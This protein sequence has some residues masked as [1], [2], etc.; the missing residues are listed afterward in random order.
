MGST[1]KEVANPSL[2]VREERF[3]FSMRTDLANPLVRMA[4]ENA[5]FPELVPNFVDEYADGVRPASHRRRV[6]RRVALVGVSGEFFCTARDSLEERARV[7]RL[8]SS[9]GIATATTSTSR[10]SKPRPR[11]ATARIT[12]SPPRRS[13]P[14]RQ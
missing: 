11:G 12:G 14:A 8:F 13:G 3:K 2:E 4:Y 10:P 7:G 1:T 9:S 5:F 6:Q